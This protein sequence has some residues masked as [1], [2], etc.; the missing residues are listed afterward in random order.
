MEL[1]PQGKK[2][3]VKVLYED[4]QRINEF[5]KLV[6]K[7]D[8]ITLDLERQRQEKEYLD[9]ISM[10]IELI[11]E[12]DELQ[13]K[14]GELFVYLKQSEVVELLE[15]DIEAIEQ[16]IT[17]LENQDEEVEKKMNSLKVILYNKFGDN[18]NLER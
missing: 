1:L 4:Q 6:L 14:V 7:K 2:N 17:E 11:D 15:K 12:D 9:D 8:D 5:S 13:Y 3:T 16:R 10:E 18:I